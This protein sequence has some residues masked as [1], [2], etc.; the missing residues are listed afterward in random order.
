M[1]SHD[2]AYAEPEKIKSIDAEFL[3]GHRFPYQEDI[4]L[5]DDVDLMAAS[6]GDRELEQLVEHR[7]AR[8]PRQLVVIGLVPDVRLA[9]GHA[10]LHRIQ[11]AGQPA[12]LLAAFDVDRFVVLAAFDTPGRGHQLPDRPR[13]AAPEQHRDDHGEQQRGAADEVHR[14]PDRVER[15]EHLAGRLQQHQVHGVVGGFDPDNV[16]E[17]L[18]VPHL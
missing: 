3:A 16:R 5:L 15:R 10:L 7:P 13:C 4:S 12:E 9:F 6:P 2:L 14:I 18:L 11:C 8:E 1:S 17:K